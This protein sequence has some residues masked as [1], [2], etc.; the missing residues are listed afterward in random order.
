M[1]DYD[2]TPAEAATFIAR[3]LAGLE[4]I[5]RDARLAMLAYILGIARQEAE[6]RAKDRPR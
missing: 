3:Q 6:A 2:P 5:A 4:E 1:T